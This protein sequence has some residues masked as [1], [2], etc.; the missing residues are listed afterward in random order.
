MLPDIDTLQ[1]LIRRTAHEELLPRFHRVERRI[2]DDGSIL[3]EADLAMNRR[4]REQLSESWPEVT[5]LSEEMPADEQER[6]LAGSSQPLWVLDPLDGTSNF[7]AGLPFFAVSL[8]L[9]VET[10]VRIGIVYDPI[11]DESFAA[12]AGQGSTLNDTS[13]RAAPNGLPLERAVALVDFKRLAPALRSRLA[14]NA[15][16]SSQ[17]NFGSCALEWCWMA[18]GRGHVYLHGGM[19]LWDF[20]AGSLIL[21]EAGGYSQTLDGEDVF[22]PAMTP[23]SVIASGDAHLFA[24]WCDWLA[25]T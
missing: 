6:C 22:R 15:P 14:Q 19:K 1:S 13:L 20:A 21:S 3:T 16:Y 11:R 23:R 25:G 18:A 2:K 5:F 10:R 9:V 12:Q 4:L 7:A 8:A 24:A 17:R